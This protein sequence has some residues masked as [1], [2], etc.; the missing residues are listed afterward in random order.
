MLLKYKLF[1]FHSLIVI[2]PKAAD[3][4]VIV[5]ECLSFV[6]VFKQN[7]RCSVWMTAC[8]IYLDQRFFTAQHKAEMPASCVLLLRA[9]FQS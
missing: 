1:D 2:L 9:R 3:F 6:T 5:V 8:V 7:R 4:S